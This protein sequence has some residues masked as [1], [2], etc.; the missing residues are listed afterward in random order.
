MD[1]TE[2]CYPEY[3][4]HVWLRGEMNYNSTLWIKRQLFDSIRFIL[5]DT[6]TWQSIELRFSGVK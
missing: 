1:R 2:L 3:S 5:V 6:W 4:T